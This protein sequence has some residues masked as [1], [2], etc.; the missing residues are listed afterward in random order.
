MQ[1][2]ILSTNA[3]RPPSGIGVIDTMV[4][5]PQVDRTTWRRPMQA[6]LR[7]HESLDDFQHAA[8]YMYRDLPDTSHVADS[9]SYLLHA[10]DKVG[11]DKALVPIGLD[12][13]EP[14]NELIRSDPDRF[15]GT[16]LVDPNQGMEATRALERAVVDFGA[17]AAVAFPCGVVPQVPINDKRMYPIYAK[18]VDLGIPICINTGIPGPRVPMTPQDPALLD[19]VCWAFPDLNIVMRHG[20][21]PW[22]DLVAQLLRKWPNLYY[23]TSAYA[24]KRYPV[25]IMSLA[26]GRVREKLIYGGYFPSGLSLDAIF[27]QFPLVEL[28]DEAWHAFLRG[29][30]LRVFGLADGV[31]RAVTSAAY[32]DRSDALVDGD[33]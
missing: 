14:G 17:V 2:K 32:W 24:P 19:E 7:D 31:P 22:F 16:F 23:S 1:N 10:M 18:C 21:G 27:D 13:H 4:G 20:G 8:S 30:A 5:L 15:A 9:H 28:D 26:S 12:P 29:N 33:N 6:S 25:E 11:V 3:T